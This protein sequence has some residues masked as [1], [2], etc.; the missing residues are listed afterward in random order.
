VVLFL[1]TALAAS[2]VGALLLVFD[3]PGIGWLLTG[4]ATAGAIATA[5]TAPKPHRDRFGWAA[6]SVALLAVGTL[7]A[8]GWLFVLCVLAAILTTALAVTAGR[9]VKAILAVLPISP[10]ASARGLAWATRGLARFRRA[11]DVFTA[12]RLL[13][14]IIVTC[15]L[16]LVFGG[17]F[18]SSDPAFAELAS[19]LI[20]RIDNAWVIARWIIVLP[21]VLLGILA[22]AFLRA[23][24]PSWE[25][26]DRP[27]NLPVR[28]YEWLLPMAAL[29]TLFAAF[30]IVQAT[31]LFGGAKHV[32][33]TAGLTYA[34]Y[35]RSG[36]W[37]LL[38]V[39]GLTLGVIAV[40]VPLAPR[41]DKR[42]RTVV[43]SLL[44]PLAGLTLVIVAS[45]LYRMGVYAQAY[46]LTQL[47]VLVFACEVWLGVVFVMVLVAGIKLR[48]AWLPRMVVATGVL[49]LLTL[50]AVNPDRT[51]AAY[52]LSRDRIDVGYLSTLSADAV[53]A[54]DKAPADVRA[55]VLARLATDLADSPDAWYELNLAR[56]A[57]RDILDKRPPGRAA[58]ACYH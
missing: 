32:L 11:R 54:L 26:L 35:A 10:I 28:R 19:R 16:L 55:C 2:V 7:R 37:Q 52:N 39:T 21:A 23:A 48:A 44:G 24:P 51:I 1:L 22:A 43:R 17:L 6:A 49:T 12:P 15:L 58:A 33:T 13:L 18:A 34:Q 27:I 20:P 46:G 50:A 31:V 25:K 3:R 29:D 53:P 38:V 36:F 9:S 40:A 42:D 14:S 4:L 47:R 8:A 45:A 41:A 30:V 56:V 5:R 57:A